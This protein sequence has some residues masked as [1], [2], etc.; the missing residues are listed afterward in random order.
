MRTF[1]YSEHDAAFYVMALPQREK[2][3]ATRMIK[4]LSDFGYLNREAR[5][6]LSYYGGIIC[7]C[8]SQPM[9][10]F[11]CRILEEMLMDEYLEEA[12]LASLL[13]E[14]YLEEDKRVRTDEG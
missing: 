4:F 9:A 8:D 12:P 5:L 3:G 1:Y 2:E 14:A 7:R 6:K 11:L 10:Q 13:A